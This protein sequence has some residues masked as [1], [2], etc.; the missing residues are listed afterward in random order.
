MNY[1]LGLALLL[2]TLTLGGAHAQPAP[3]FDECSFA[4]RNSYMTC[5]QPCSSAV[6]G[7]LGSQAKS[8]AGLTTNQNQ[9]YLNCATQQQSCTNS[10][11]ELPYSFIPPSTVPTIVIPPGQ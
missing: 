9:C 5:V 3:S 11:G 10:C 8:S 6:G 7:V 4:C 2:G 1:R